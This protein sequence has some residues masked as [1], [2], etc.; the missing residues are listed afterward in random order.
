M[1]NPL[2]VNLNICGI[3]QN[4][5]A[6]NPSQTQMIPAGN[7]FQL[8]DNCFQTEGIYRKLFNNDLSAKMWISGECGIW[9][10]WLWLP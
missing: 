1:V 4:A 5:P 2:R 6:Q 9:R 3:G 10:I 8:T 7:V